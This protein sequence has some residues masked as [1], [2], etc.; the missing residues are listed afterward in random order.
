M[1]QVQT[2]EKIPSRLMLT[3]RGTAGHGSLPRPDNPVVHL[4][5][6]IARVADADQPVKL[7]ATTRRYLR[8]IAKL[9][10]Y[11]WIGTYTARLEAPRSAAAAANEIRVRDPEIDAQ[12]RTTVS[13]T[14]LSAGVKINVIP[15]VAQ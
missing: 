8:E 7:N 2:A 14:M 4:A 13:P 6:A 12:L 15:N 3:A 1:Y 9:P 11:R 5:R 10:D